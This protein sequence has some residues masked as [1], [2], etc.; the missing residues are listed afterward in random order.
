MRVIPAAYANPVIPTA[1]T[2]TTQ[3]AAVKTSTPS[4]GPAVVVELSATAQNTIAQF[5]PIGADQMGPMGFLKF[6]PIGW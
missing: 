6:G 5:G 1:T 3:A 4:A 2:K